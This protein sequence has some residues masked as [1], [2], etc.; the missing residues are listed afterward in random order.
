MLVWWGVFD[1]LANVR[2]RK[3]Y[4]RRQLRR[5]THYVQSTCVRAGQGDCPFLEFLEVWVK[6]KEAL[7]FVDCDVVS[8]LLAKAQ[9]E[10]GLTR[11]R[12]SQASRFHQRLPSGQCFLLQ[13]S[14][15]FCLSVSYPTTSTHPQSL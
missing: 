8:K 9:A 15:S 2:R 13:L 14:P 1:C 4:K 3:A 12:L 10:E 7:A 5:Y 6:L 11:N